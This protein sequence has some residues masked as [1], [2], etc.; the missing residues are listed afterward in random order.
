M[1]LLSIVGGRIEEV[2]DDDVQGMLNRTRAV[3]K[4]LLRCGKSICT[5]FGVFQF[6]YDVEICLTRAIVAGRNCMLIRIVVRFRKRYN[7]LE[8]VVQIN[9]L[10]FLP[11]D[12]NATKMVRKSKNLNL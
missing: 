12:Q 6:D 1:G 11:F 4:F 7:K 5:S 2:E 10:V 9:V 3:A 8:I